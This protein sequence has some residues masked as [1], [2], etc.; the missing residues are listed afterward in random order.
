MFQVRQVFIVRQ[1]SAGNV[2]LNV[3]GERIV[4]M[5][6]CNHNTLKSVMMVTILMVIF[7]LQFVKLSRPALEEEDRP[8]VAKEAEREGVLKISVQL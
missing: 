5:V 2:I 3:F 1:L 8:V 6:F 4:E 7:V